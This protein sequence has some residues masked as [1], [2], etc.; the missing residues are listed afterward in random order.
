M[1]GNIIRKRI[2]IP[3]TVSPVIGNLNS[4]FNEKLEIIDPIIRLTF[5]S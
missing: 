3:I 1:Q 4:I 2:I 5:C